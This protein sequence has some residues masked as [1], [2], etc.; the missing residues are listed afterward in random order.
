MS[1]NYLDILSALSQKM[2]QE[3]C[4]KRD[5]IKVKDI[6]KVSLTREDGLTLNKGYDTREKYIVIVGKDELGRLLGALLINHEIATFIQTD[7]DMMNAQYMLKQE[8][9]KSF[10]KEDSWLD[11]TELFSLSAQKIEDRK[12]EK[13]ASLNDD[14][15]ERVKYT[16]ATTEFIDEAQKMQF[17]L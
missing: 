14:D 13:V 7:D 3:S 1:K 17:G 9:Y 2:H 11:C 15:F 12:G 6:I 10:L 8:S 4:V 16:I 5:S